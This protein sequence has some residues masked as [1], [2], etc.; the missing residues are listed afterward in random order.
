MSGT[1]RAKAIDRALA[2][3]RLA[4]ELL[5]AETPTDDASSVQRDLCYRQIEAMSGQLL[6]GEIPDGAGRVTGMA[7]MAADQWDPWSPVTD[8]V[9]SAEHEYLRIP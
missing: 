8:A 4:L 7:H 6:A 1:N 5:D 9:I 2:A 3:C